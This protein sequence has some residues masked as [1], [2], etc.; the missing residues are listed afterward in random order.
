[1]E[2]LP[3]KSLKSAGSVGAVVMACIG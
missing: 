3:T 1:V 2:E